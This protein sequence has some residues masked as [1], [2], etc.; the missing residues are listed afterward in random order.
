[1]EE[2]GNDKG[3][4]QVSVQPGEDGENYAYT[5][6]HTNTY[7]SRT[8]GHN[9]LDPVPNYNYYCRTGTIHG[10]KLPRPSIHEL[11]ATYVPPEPTGLAGVYDDPE[12]GQEV[13]EDGPKPPEPILFGWFRG[14]GMRVMVNIWGVLM[15]LR[16]PWIT[17]QSG[18][19]LMWLIIIIS[20]SITSTACLSLCAVCT[21]GKVSRGGSYFLIS[22]TLGVE[23]GA[24]MGVIYSFA[25]CV[26]IAS[27]TVGFAE[28]LR[29]ILHGG[30][31]I[32]VDKVN[33]LRIIGVIAVTFL[34]GI[35][36][37]GL[38]W[39][40]KAQL[41][42]FAL[43]IIALL[44]YL[45]GT[46]MPSPLDKQAKGFFGY[47]TKIFNDNFTPSFRGPYD[48]FRLLGIFLP[49][50]TAILT[51][52]NICGDLK[53]PA[54]AIPKGT[55]LGIAVTGLS[56][57]M[58]STT[59]GSVVLRDAT[60]NLSDSLTY[61]APLI[62]N[63]NITSTAMPSI[64]STVL[65]ST[66]N[67][68]MLS[69]TIDSTMATANTTMAIANSTV[70]AARVCTF[71]KTGCDL[72]WNFGACNVT[73]SIAPGFSPCSYGFINQYQVMA[74]VSAW[75]PLVYA[76]IFGAGLSSALASLISAPKCFQGVAR[77][78][79]Y[80]GITI[81]GKGYGRNQEPI[82]G[83]LLAYTIG[84]CFI[85]IADLNLI[86]PIT[87]CCFL[88]T[89][90]ILNFSVFHSSV[91]KAPGWRPDFKYFHP[92]IA[93]IT[94][95]FDIV[96]MFLILWWG[97]VL[98]LGIWVVL[99]FYCMYKKPEVNWG[100]SVQA[101][102]FQTALATTLNLDNVKEHIKVFR[103]NCLV[104]TGPPHLRPALVDFVGT[105]TKG[106]SLMVC[107][108][109]VVAG[110]NKNQICD[111]RQTEHG[112]WLR[113]RNINSFYTAIVSNS[114]NEGASALLQSTGLGKLRPNL[115][116][117]GF[118]NS[119][120]GEDPATV[121]DY[122]QIIHNVFDYSMALAIL[123]VKEGL[124]IK[125]MPEVQASIRTP[126]NMAFQ[127]DGSG[128]GVGKV[129]GLVAK[130]AL[131]MDVDQTEDK[132]GAPEAMPQISTVFQFSQGKRTIDIYWLF[133]DGGMT[134]LIPYL[135]SKKNRWGE[136]KMRVFMAGKLDRLEE[137]KQNMSRLI[138]RFRLNVDD[139]IILT[140]V[141]KK[142]RADKMKYFEDLIM[143]YRLNDGFKDP[144][145]VEQLRKDC[146]WKISDHEI[147]TLREKT[148]RQ[149][150]L[151]ELMHEHSK[152]AA[153]IV[154]SM[155]VIQKGRCP[156]A[157][158]M[159]WLEVLSRDLPPVLIMRGNHTN[160]LTIYSQ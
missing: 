31:L 12:A 54:T 55:F 139:V 73:T 81:F 3:R 57:V 80:P 101:M 130:S 41:I 153:L 35:A 110:P 84:I 157:M 99:Y 106:V 42:F 6:T 46:V 83:Y 142:P 32:M 93:I 27:H 121:H 4:F 136:C 88:N 98:S 38:A 128:G 66:I 74:M 62:N 159:A 129:S 156:S 105:F 51:G 151:N 24:P 76:G 48:F 85:C 1:M 144:A 8:F 79:I 37:A 56:Y 34:L 135:L 122:V 116:F 133:D 92:A 160:V 26:S 154:V 10:K 45:L 61:I 53:E 132:N 44:D 15:F 127:F 148:N 87:A 69:S 145:E 119:W 113:H 28:T 59:I 58:I 114:L 16:L 103:P 108:N 155:P 29:D 111:L 112:K 134:L 52:A 95:V 20:C 82:F 138:A 22:R 33:D 123:R 125:N 68:T 140:D 9:T 64:L 107:G 109:V 152:D 94:M 25:S 72:G 14:V 67:S 11:H 71:T 117:L 143:P 100:S 150:K 39:E 49:S 141:N 70:A 147:L 63:T 149:L 118:M 60:G 104:L 97:A 50:V 91:V 96:I 5:D 131:S 146:P 89:Y 2:A 102:G 75:A 90:V 30:N 17:A 18:I 77:D 86:S 7:Y 43:I 78:N 23:L 65:S 13:E 21:N 120:L 137:D 40:N 124:D 158:G 47:N 36:L 126:V 115:V 19:G